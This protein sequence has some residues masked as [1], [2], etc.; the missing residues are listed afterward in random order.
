MRAPRSTLLAAGA[1]SIG[2][3]VPVT[4]AAATLAVHVQRDLAVGK[5]VH[6][7]FRARALT[8]GGYYYAVI[9]LEPY[10][11]YTRSAPPPCSTSSNMLHTDYGY[12]RGGVVSLTLT[13]SRS[14]TGHWCRGGVYAGAIYAVPHRPPCERRYPCKSE[15]YEPP[16]PCW[17]TDG[18]IVCGVVVRPREWAYPNGL[19][20][21]LARGTS[22]VARFSVSIPH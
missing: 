10:R 18:H 21:P 4:C 12:P 6:V 19:P 5:S 17:G 20:R 22:T 9:V 11:S 8:Q 7:S 16:S 3:A 13:P 15:P 1:L 2:S 14:R